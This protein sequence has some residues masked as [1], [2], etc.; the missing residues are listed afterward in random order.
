MGRDHVALGNIAALLMSLCSQPAT[1][2]AS[3]T[4]VSDPMHY[5]RM[6]Q[7]WEIG[8]YG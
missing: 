3:Q 5:Y 4:K 7:Q 8:A 6:L 2:T 1:E